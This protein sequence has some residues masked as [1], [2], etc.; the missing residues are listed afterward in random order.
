MQPMEK[1]DYKFWAKKDTWTIKEAA[2]L[3]HRREPFNHRS[4]RINNRDIPT[5]FLTVQKTYFLLNSVPWWGRYNENG[6]T[7]IHPYSILTEAINKELPIPSALL[8]VVKKRFEREQQKAE[9]IQED[10][11]LG[12]VKE[13]SSPMAVMDAPQKIIEEPIVHESS[14]TTRERRNLLKTIGIL[15][16]LLIGD[17][18]KRSPRYCRGNKLNV[19]RI[20]DTLTKKAQDLGLELVGLKSLNRK[21]SEALEMIEEERPSN[22]K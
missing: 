7:G 12:P 18:G 9:S 3:L 1:P 11:N 13:A 2:L 15:V 19:Y 10:S 4:L 20:A 22:K 16:Y 14:L 5:E 8:S 21:L 6:Y 17:E